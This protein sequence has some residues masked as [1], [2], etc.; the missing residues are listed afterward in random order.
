MTSNALLVH[1]NSSLVNWTGLLRSALQV[2]ERSNISYMSKMPQDEHGG[3][4]PQ[5]PNPL[6][7]FQP[8]W[9]AGCRPRGTSSA[10]SCTPTS[11]GGH[12]GKPAGI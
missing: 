5:L 2:A 11:A 12:P 8:C 7:D 1:A 10:A 4:A 9:R 3:A 6:P